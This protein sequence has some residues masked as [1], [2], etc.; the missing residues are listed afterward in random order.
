MNI[1]YLTED[2]TSN[3]ISSHPQD[4]TA[5]Q[6]NMFNWSTSLTGHTHTHTHTHTSN[7]LT[8]TYDRLQTSELFP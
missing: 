3:K 7:G 8:S 1:S 6:N 2:E 5:L 4:T